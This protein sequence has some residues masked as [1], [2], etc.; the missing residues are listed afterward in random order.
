MV[1]GICTVA[2]PIIGATAVSF[3]GL[4]TVFI[5]NSVSYFLSAAFSCFIIYETRV[6]ENRESNNVWQDIIEG[7]LY[8]KSQNR[9]VIVISIIA[10]VHFFMGSLMVML[11]FLAKSLSGNG[12]RNLGYL[13]MMMGLGLISGSVYIGSKKKKKI[14]E[15]ALIC[16]I[17]IMGL[18]FLSIGLG[19]YLLIKMVIPYMIILLL[20][21]VLIAFASVYWQT[22]LQNNIPANM[23][24]RVFSISSMA[25]N[26][27]LPIAY[28][29]FGIL[30]TYLS[31]IQVT[32]ICGISLIIFSSAII[33]IVFR[34]KYLNQLRKAARE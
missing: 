33:L 15:Y 1:N 32:F 28:G 26:I 5:F 13:E 29:V 4:S 16:F 24:G 22:L 3:L 14:S 30:M 9:M 18:C 6:Y 21:G 23:T 17:M 19:K 7:V 34:R 27:S 12:I 20:I 11:P 8:L 10:I 31:M 25:G 2:G